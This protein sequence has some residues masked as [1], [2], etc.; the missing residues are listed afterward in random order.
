MENSNMPHFIKADDNKIINEKAILWVKKMDDCLEVC[1][2][3]D[4]CACKVNTH[5]IC[6]INSLDSYNKLNS[7]FN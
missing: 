6:K 2:K 5:R 7:L 4:G 1:V 3:Q